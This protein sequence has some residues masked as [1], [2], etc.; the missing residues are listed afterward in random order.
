M[1]TDG[2]VIDGRVAAT[3][4][5]SDKKKRQ[6]QAKS[7]QNELLEDLLKRVEVLEKQKVKTDYDIYTMQKN[8]A[9]IQ[10]GSYDPK[11]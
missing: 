8:I 1:E 5:D 4:V 2:A 7:P 6:V 9:F 10:S 11:E 3:S